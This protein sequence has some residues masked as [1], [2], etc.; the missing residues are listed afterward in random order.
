MKYPIDNETMKIMYRLHTGMEPGSEMNELLDA[1]V[2][3]V[4][5]AYAEGIKVGNR[6]E[7]E[8]VC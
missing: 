2:S 7:K 6:M 8:M 1:I 4:N 3:V 5:H